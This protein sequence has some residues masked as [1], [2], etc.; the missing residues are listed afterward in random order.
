[1]WGFPLA[2]CTDLSVTEFESQPKNEKE[3]LKFQ[4]FRG[5]LLFVMTTSAPARS[6]L[7][8]AGSP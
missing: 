5:S 7:C 4:K 3:T 6:L 2:P 8:R 1:M